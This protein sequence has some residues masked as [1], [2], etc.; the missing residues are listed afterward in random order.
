LDSRS[1][2]EARF[3]LMTINSTYSGLRVLDLSTNI[4]GP[5]AAMIFGDLGADVIKVERF[6]NG[7]DT[8]ALP[9]RWDGNA[10]V[11]MAVNRNKRSVLLDFKNAKGRAAV[12]KLT[13]TAHVVIESF[14]PGIATALG[15]TFEDFLACNPRIAV[16]SISAFGDGPIGRA[17]PGYDALVQA[18]SGMMSFTGHPD[19]PSVRLAPSV[20]DLST[21]LW[22]VIGLMAALRRI[23][24]GGAGEHVC[25]SLLDSAF[26]LMCHQ[27]LGY[28]ATGEL[29]IKLGSGA[30][31]AAP[32]RVFKASDGE[33][34]IATATDAQFGRLCDALGIQGIS[35]DQRFRTID[36]RIA[37]RKELDEV[38]GK[39]VLL[40]SVDHWIQILGKAGISAS[41]VN[42]LAEALKMAVT[43]ERR[44]LVAP[45]SGG[46]DTRLKL[47]RL[48]IDAAGSAIRFPPP[49]LGE[50]SADV[51]RESGL[52]EELI[53]Q[54]T[55]PQHGGRD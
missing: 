47:L 38:I 25:P 40:E 9:P 34:L 14:P 30:P 31:S 46:S 7:D 27:L 29:P 54:L 3:D 20:L 48:P 1:G 11:F 44:L 53:S 52:S 55:Q 33:I 51:L 21:G 19:T 15:L 32:Y 18:A 22:A 43:S 42:T 23:E 2:E 37:H 10:T 16:C 5:Y 12:L 24:K 6:P 50:H 26:N 41:R 36:D 13:E 4:A 49:A 17:L 39:Q 35:A 45:Q 8:R 28:T